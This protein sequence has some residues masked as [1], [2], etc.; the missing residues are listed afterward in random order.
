MI[1]RFVILFFIVLSLV[2]LVIQARDSWA[3]SPLSKG[4]VG[5]LITEPCQVNTVPEGSNAIGIVPDSLQELRETLE[6]NNNRYTNIVNIRD[7]FVDNSGVWKYRDLT[8]LKNVLSGHDVIIMLDEPFW[9]VRLE[10]WRG[11][12]LACQE[13][14]SNYPQTRELF[15]RV[16]FELG[17]QLYQ[18]E[19]YLELIYA[20]QEYGK[21][22]FM[23]YADH[24]GWNCYSN[25]FYDCDGYSQLDYAVWTY[26]A[27]LS[28]QKIFL[29]AGAFLESSYMQDEVK[30]ITQLE[31]FFAAYNTYRQYL[32]G[33]GVFSWGDYEGNRITGAYNVP[34][35]RNTIQKLINEV[36]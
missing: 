32:S 9:R 10:C 36:K 16:K 25:N 8:E 21:P 15:K 27:M 2:Y 35:I 12:S 34:N 24:I 31:D 30:I 1:K 33:I 28:H 19:S 5:V 6:L 23:D 17:Y 18:V 13:V 7:W 20:R 22:Q 3:S 26:D 29:V 4:I 14:E 11:K